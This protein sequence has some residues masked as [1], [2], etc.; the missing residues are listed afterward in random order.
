MENLS[1]FRNTVNSSGDASKKITFNDIFIKAVG[2]ASTKYPDTRTQWYGDYVR[3]FEQV[4]VSFAVDTG[5]G[6]ITPI[7]PNVPRTKLTKLATSTKDL[8]S[9]ARNNK[10]APHEYQVSILN[11]LKLA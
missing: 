1:E 7:V 11:L 9:K 10:L 8:V 4:D 6:L 2:I 3:T 5:S